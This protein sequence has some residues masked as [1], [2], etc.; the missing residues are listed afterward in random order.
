[1]CYLQGKLSVHQ[2][3]ENPFMGAVKDAHWGE[4]GHL[5]RLGECGLL[6]MGAV[7]TVPLSHLWMQNDCHFPCPK[8]EF[9]LLQLKAFEHI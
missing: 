7:K 3:T 9:I 4:C 1:M 5:L 6:L 8:G 2:R